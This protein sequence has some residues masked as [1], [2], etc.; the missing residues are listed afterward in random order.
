MLFVSDPADEPAVEE[1]QKVIQ[2]LDIDHPAVVYLESNVSLSR[3]DMED[4]PELRGLWDAVNTYDFE[5]YASYFTI[6][7]NSNG[8][9]NLLMRLRDKKE[10]LGY[11]NETGET[12]VPEGEDEIHLISYMFRLMRY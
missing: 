10:S 3:S 6:L 11:L 12:F 1:E 7:Q 5:K 9:M 2:P 8:Y 4:I